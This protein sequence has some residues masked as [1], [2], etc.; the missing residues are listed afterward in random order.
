[1]KSDLRYCPACGADWRGVE[2]PADARHHYRLGTTHYGRLIGVEDP[3]VFDGVSWWRCPDCHSEWE[4]FGNN[5]DFRPT[6][7]GDC[8]QLLDDTGQWPVCR[9][10]AQ[11]AL[12]DRPGS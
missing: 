6:W 2:I 12:A 10:C 5:V 9:A 7:C 8:G 11:S 4:R 3:R 1:M